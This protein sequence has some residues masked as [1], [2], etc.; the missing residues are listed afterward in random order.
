[1]T[2]GAPDS[3]ATSFFTLHIFGCSFLIGSDM[4]EHVERFMQSCYGSLHSRGTNENA[5][6]ELR[7]FRHE[8]NICISKDADDRE[9]LIESG[10]SGAKLLW[11]GK[12][13]KGIVSIPC[14]SDK[15]ISR[16][17]YSGISAFIQQSLKTRDIFFLHA[18]SVGWNGG[19]VL[20]VG[21]NGSGK[22]SMMRSL[23]VRDASYLSDDAA[24]LV[25]ADSEIAEIESAPSPEVISAIGVPEVEI[26]MLIERGFTPGPDPRFLMPPRNRKSAPV[27]AILFPEAEC[28]RAELVSLTKKQSL[29]RILMSLKTPVFEDE[30]KKCFDICARLAERTSAALVKIERGKPF[31]A[32]KIIEFCEENLPV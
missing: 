19:A 32:E 25:A 31:P 26:G 16:F 18:S 11:N 9:I 21:P 23:L 14:A 22:S 7:L 1:M 3:K 13:H 4:P 12:T 10:Q 28:G 29:L 27:K 30:Y 20:F 24:P 6:Y 8:A 17:V 2:A 5:D 15:K